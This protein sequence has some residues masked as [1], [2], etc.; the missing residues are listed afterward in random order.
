MLSSFGTQPTVVV[1]VIVWSLANMM[2]V[3]L[4]LKVST[5]SLTLYPPPFRCAFSHHGFSQP[6]KYVVLTPWIA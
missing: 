2:G 1:C 4:L 3:V 5:R 6:W